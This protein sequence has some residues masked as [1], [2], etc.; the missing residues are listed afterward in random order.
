[1]SAENIP[2]FPKAFKNQR[3][4]DGARWKRAALNAA[5]R[6]SLESD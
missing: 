3:A 1:M 2:V 5:Q 6:V 4:D